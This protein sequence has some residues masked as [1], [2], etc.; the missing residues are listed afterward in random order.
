MERTTDRIA[1]NPIQWLATEDGW[2]DFAR[3]P[4]PRQLLAQ[5][6]A[7]GFEGV[8]A[9]VPTGWSV[10]QYRTALDEVGLAPAPGYLGLGLAEDGVDQR[11]LLERAAGAARE[12]VALGLGDIVVSAGMTRDATRVRHP[13][14]GYAPDRARLERL[15]E[16]IGRVAETTLAE[17]VRAAL[18]AHVGTW[19]ET[20]VE[21]RV[22]LDAIGAR[23][24]GFAPDTGHLAWAEADVG[25]LLSD[26]AA[27][28]TA[29][30]VKDCRRSVARRARDEDLTYQQTVMAGLWAEPGRGELDLEAMLAALPAAFAGWLIVEVD[31]PDI[32]DPY[33]SA[34][35]SAA[36]MRR[37][38]A[39]R[40]SGGRAPTPS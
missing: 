1:L 8:F 23:Q 4:E 9:E 13:A 28:V 26:Y 39:G 12:H 19:V 7:A 29:V 31:R 11:E 14:R 10:E 22:V 36:W 38:A 37:R 3:R 18:H 5:I 21:T 40:D 20:E 6:K 2:L 16:V 35:A 25:A 33:E 24:L 32:P 30:H 17:G 15:V 34:K 27:R